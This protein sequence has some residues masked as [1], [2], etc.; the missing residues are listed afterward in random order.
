MEVM[1]VRERNPIIAQVNNQTAEEV[2][3]STYLGSNISNK[4]NTT[5]DIYNR[6]G[7]VSDVFRRLNS[8]WISKRISLKTK[9]NSL[10]I[11]VAVESTSS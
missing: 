4:G 8:I 1:E 11:P 2:E 9:L 7:K 10:V 6:L 3:S 5:Q